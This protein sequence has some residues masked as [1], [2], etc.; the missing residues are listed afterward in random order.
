M[1]NFS[2]PRA[3]VGMQSGRASVLGPRHFHASAWERNKSIFR[4][5]EFFILLTLCATPVLRCEIVEIAIK[6]VGVE[7]L[8]GSGWHGIKLN[9]VEEYRLKPLLQFIH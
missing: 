6:N 9:V 2:F 8:A 1:T 5:T 3:G 4:S 7:A